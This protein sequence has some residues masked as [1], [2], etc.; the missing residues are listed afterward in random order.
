MSVRILKSSAEMC[1]GRPHFSGPALP[2]GA[3]DMWDTVALPRDSWITV[4]SG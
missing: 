3:T 1:K 4:V 2:Q